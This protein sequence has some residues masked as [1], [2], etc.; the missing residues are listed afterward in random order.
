MNF[1]IFSAAVIVIDYVLVMTWL[2][3]L[4]V[5]YHNTCE[6]G[7]GKCCDQSVATSTAVGLAADK[8]SEAKLAEKKSRIVRFFEDA[9]PYNLLVKPVK[10][11][12]ALVVI[13]AASM[14]PATMVAVQLTPQ[15]NAEQFLPESHPFQQYF[16]LQNEFE[17]SNEDATVQM[18]IVWGF[19]PGNELD[20]TGVNLLA[21]H[22]FKGTPVYKSGFE[23]GPLEQKHVLRACDLV[24]ADP[25]T[26]RRVD[27]L[28][29]NTTVESFCF[30]RGFRDWRST[31]GLSFPTAAGSFGDALLQWLDN[32]E[33]ARSAWQ[34][35]IGFTASE[36]GG[37]MQLAWFKIRAGSKLK[38]QSYLPAETL[39]GH[40][41]D[42]EA[43]LSRV[44]SNA[45][46]LL[47]PAF[48][49]AGLDTG[50]ANKWVHMV[51][52]ETYVRMALSGAAMGLALAFIVILLATHNLIVALCAFG[53][54]VC[55]L[56]QVIATTVSMGWQLGS[57]EAICIM[58]LC[59][60]A[61]DYVVHLAHSYMESHQATR[62]E[63][64]H[65]ALKDMGIS[66]FWGMAT[67]AVAA[68][69]LAVCQLQ[70]L[71]K[72]G[73]FFLLTIVFSYLWSVLFLMPLLALVGPQS[74][75][76]K[77]PM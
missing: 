77:L 46:A 14:I 68:C 11:R 73:M 26:M 47:G 24:E 59:G 20:L 21:D 22:T 29:G 5:V 70:T 67:S 66:V 4:V 25:L 10:V 50:V 75:K 37:V 43:L 54:I 49:T 74:A 30:L 55:I 19:E 18:Q 8:E 51:L 39:R 71:A 13:F 64:V 38:Q 40:H 45:P 63:R 28:T 61:V 27:T 35:D 65:D 56:I 42:W 36:G 60:F 17:S 69:V 48:Q 6:K 72:F 62:L 12:A 44:N 76:S 34:S 58:T 16:E 7:C 57:N 53:T 1:G 52:Q 3:A 32:D 41:E 2:C 23:V 33:E 9:F 15:T 31:R